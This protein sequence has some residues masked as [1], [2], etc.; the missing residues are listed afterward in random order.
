MTVDS[1][2]AT[3]IVELVHPHLREVPGLLPCLVLLAH[4]RARQPH[5]RPRGGEHLHDARPALY[6]PVGPLLDVVGAQALP[7]GRRKV[8]V[9][10]R[11]GLGLLQHR[12]R[13]RAAPR[14]HVARRVVHGRHGG[15]VAPAEHLRHDP[16]HAAPEL[17]GAGLAHAVA[18][19]VDRAA[20]PRGALEDLAER[21]DESRVGVRDDEPHARRPARADGSQ[22]GE[23][24]VVGLGVNHVDAQDAPPAARVAADGRDDGRGGHAAPAAALDVGGVEPDVGHRRAV[25]GPRAELLD[26]GVKVRRDGAHLVLGEPGHAH[27]LRDAP[28]LAGARA[29]GVHLGDGGHEGAVRALV[30]L[31]HVVREEAAGAELRDAQRQR[32]DAGGEA[33]LPVAVAAVRPAAAQLVG[34]GVHHGVYDLLGEAP[35]QLLHVDG[36]VV[37]TGHGEHVRLRV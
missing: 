18:H 25:E 35:E 7:V 3:V 24:R 21:P 1:P 28:H 29:G 33:A 5:Q 2:S 8:E 36:T 13:P 32:A 6:L 23:P 20:L 15:G 37:E 17:P 11:V 27:L 9:G 22:E 10:Q 30:A 34:L 12:R 16:A 26:V 4:D 31:D 14:Q 19:E